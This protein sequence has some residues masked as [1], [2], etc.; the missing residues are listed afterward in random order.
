MNL[1]L[2]KRRKIIIT[3]F[4]LTIGLLSTQL[5]DFNLRFKFIGG[6]GVVAYI[7]SLWSLW[8]GLNKTK[9][10][11]ILILPAFYTLAVTS[12]YFVL[13]IRWLTRLPIAFIFGLSFYLLLLSQNIFNVASIRTIPLYRAAST[14]GFLFTWVTSLLFYNV[15]DSFN[16]SFWWNGILVFLVSWPLVLQILWSVEMHD[17]VP[18]DVLIKSLIISLLLGEFAIAFSFWPPVVT[19]ITTMWALELSAVL[20][21]LVGISLD[22]LRKRLNKREAG[23]YLG[24]G[25]F[26]LISFFLVTSWTG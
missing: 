14:A 23:W 10:I 3:S 2:T 20:Y 8:V 16:L 24:I 12:Y 18:A 21:I 26:M 7:L 11:V 1:N 22:D 9:A 19:I 5:V 17:F 15:I 4:L 13:P 25:L 6:L